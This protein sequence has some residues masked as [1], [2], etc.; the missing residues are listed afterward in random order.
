[1]RFEDIETPVLLLDEAKMNRNIA[2]MRARVDSLGVAFRPHLKTSKCIQVARR[3][4]GD[5]PSAVCVS[6]LKEAEF[7]LAHGFTDILYAVGITPGKL[8]HVADLRARGCD[9]KI[10]LD[11]NEAADAVSDFARQRSVA[12]PALVEI[13]SDGQR[14]GV[15]PDDDKLLAIGKRLGS[16]LCGLMTHAGA[17]YDC[18]GVQEIRDM[19]EQERGKTVRAA[20][21]LREAGMPCS[22]VSVGSTP[23]ALFAEHL[24][25]VTEVRAGVF[26]FQDLVMAGLAVCQVEDIA[27]SVLCTVIGHQRERGWLITDAG[28]M[29]M[30]RDRGTARQSTAQGFGLVCD[31]SGQTIPGLVLMNTSQE[32]GIIADRSGNSAQALRFPIGTRLR[33]LPNHACATAAQ[34]AAYHVIGGRGSDDSIDD[35]WPRFSGW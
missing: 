2:R 27:I 24:S 15:A 21:R 34:H 33:I 28:W 5:P 16:L 35:V 6:T 31:E 4:V 12:L 25:G 3:L 8:Q 13:D 1:M 9:L 19:A 32:H 18:R 20:E 29:S 23:T 17:S 26:V 14:A 7:F 30:S 11:S 10:I 22:I